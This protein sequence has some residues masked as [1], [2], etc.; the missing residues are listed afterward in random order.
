MTLEYMEVIAMEFC[1]VV[2][3]RFWLVYKRRGGSFNW[4]VVALCACFIG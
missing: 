2:R 3:G 1:V 4:R